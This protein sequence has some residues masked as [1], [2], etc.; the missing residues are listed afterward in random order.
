M[1]KAQILLGEKKILFKE[2]ITMFKEEET[3]LLDLL[4]GLMGE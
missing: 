1:E 3:K 4:I 2:K